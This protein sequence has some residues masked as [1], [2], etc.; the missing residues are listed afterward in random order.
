ML[1]FIKH[2]SFFSLL[3][4]LNAC[5]QQPNQ[6]AAS[7]QHYAT[8][9]GIRILNQG[10]NAFDAAI[11]MHYALAVVHPCCGN[12]GG[13]GVMTAVLKN[14]QATVIDFREEAPQSLSATD[15]QTSNP[16]HTVGIPGAVLGMQTIHDRY[17][18]LPMKDLINPAIDLASNGYVIQEGDAKI[19]EFAKDIIHRSA[20]ASALFYPKGQVPNI[21]TVLRQ[22]NLAK[23]LT[24]IRDHGPDSFYK[25]PI[26][27]AILTKS[28]EYQG[29]LIPSDFTHYQVKERTPLRCQYRDHEIITAPAPFSGL[30]LCQTLALIE[31]MQPNPVIDS[32]P[33]GMLKRI[34]SLRMAYLDRAKYLAD[35]DF[36]EVD[37]EQLL[38]K[39]HLSRMRDYVE[40]YASG[41]TPVISYPKASQEGRHTTAFVVADK[42]GNVV[43]MTT[44]LNGYFGSGIYLDDYGFFLNNEMTD[45][46]L[47]PG[48]TANRIEP[49][50]RPMSGMTPTIVLKQ[51]QPIIALGS[52]GGSTIPTQIANTLMKLIDQ[53]LSIE[54]TL[55][56][57]RF[58]PRWNEAK[59]HIEP[60]VFDAATTKALEKRG[61]NLVEGM[62][63]IPGI[64]SWGAVALLQKQSNQWQAGMDPRRPAGSAKA[65]V[66]TP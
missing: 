8:D 49:H 33:E 2:I 61:E 48:P 7:A 37:S 36:I 27:N 58:F 12:I 20:K 57:P 24:M 34:A 3:A 30:T 13:G 60:N 42:E 53:R 35:P 17:A 18:T 22:E 10:G 50:K 5:E 46:N 21:G 39:P 43:S 47:S 31:P 4:I 65:L 14:G 55:Q 16:I 40:H 41:S 56:S 62:G 23:T 38:A 28:S 52:P 63:F 1:K 44:T 45:F 32:K 19:Y 54:D 9:V 26:S 29:K 59:I 6:A 51:Q 64:P 66:P 25:G 11:A 15:I